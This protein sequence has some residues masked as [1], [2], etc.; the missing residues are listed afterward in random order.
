MKKL[1]NDVW[2]I[3][4]SSQVQDNFFF[5]L[6][7]YWVVSNREVFEMLIIQ[8]YNTDFRSNNAFPPSPEPTKE[9]EGRLSLGEVLSSCCRSWAGKLTFLPLPTVNPTQV[10]GRVRAWQLEWI[11]N[12]SHVS[13]VW[14]LASILFSIQSG[15]K[16]TMSDS[17]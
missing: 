15:S 13:A 2:K 16:T 9:Q 11:L 8:C 5:F 17:E 6:L 7:F 3:M 4:K 14:N 12:F 1:Y 10:K